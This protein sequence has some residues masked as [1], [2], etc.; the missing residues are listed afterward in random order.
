MMVLELFLFTLMVYFQLMLHILRYAYLVEFFASLVLGYNTS[1]SAF[2]YFDNFRV[3]SIAR[4]LSSFNVVNSPY[5]ADSNTVALNGF[6][7]SSSALMLTGND[8]VNGITWSTKEVIK[9]AVPVSQLF[10]TNTYSVIKDSATVTGL[11]NL[12]TQ[13]LA[14]PDSWTI[15]LWVFMSQMNSLFR[16]T[17]I[18][19]SNGVSIQA[20]YPEGIILTTPAGTVYNTLVS[21][22]LAKWSHVALVFTVL[23]I[24]FI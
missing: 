22:T 6:N 16:N 11:T 4:Y 23:F 13:S 1:G 24:I 18:L 7:N 15:E 12:V 10:G 19:S 5:V 9:P 8:E 3:S 14:Q 21:F 17:P 2:G 20:K